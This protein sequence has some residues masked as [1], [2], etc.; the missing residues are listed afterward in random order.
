M[1][2]TEKEGMASGIRLV[3]WDAVE[4][5]SQFME[6][7]CYDKPTVDKMAFHWETGRG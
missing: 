1:L 2:T 6:N 3:N 4:Q 5:P 7:W